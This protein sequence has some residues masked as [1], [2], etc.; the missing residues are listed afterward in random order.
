LRIRQADVFFALKLGDHFQVLVRNRPPGNHDGSG[1]LAG[2]MADIRLQA[3]G[4]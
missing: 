4:E 3:A 2:M 1:C